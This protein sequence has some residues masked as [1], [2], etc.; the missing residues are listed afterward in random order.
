LRERRPAWRYAL[1]T[2]PLLA[3]AW[4]LGFAVALVVV[5]V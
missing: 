4:L 2:L 1:L 5:S 3:E